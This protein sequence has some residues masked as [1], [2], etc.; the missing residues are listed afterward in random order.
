MPSGGTS[1]SDAAGTIE[2]SM[3]TNEPFALACTGTGFAPTWL[4]G[5]LGGQSTDLNLSLLPESALDQLLGS[6]GALQDPAKANLLVRITDK[7]GVAA[8]GAKLSLSPESGLGYVITGPIAVVGD[9]VLTA[10]TQTLGLANINPG[11]VTVSVT[12]ESGIP[13]SVQPGGGNDL[14]LTMSMG[15]TGSLSFLCP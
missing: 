4:A 11:V 13:C 2:V 9:T 7:Q 1:P 15:A 14:P 10:D 12:S 3:P 8:S 5:R 6:I